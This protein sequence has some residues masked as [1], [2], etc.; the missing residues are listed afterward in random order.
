MSRELHSLPGILTLV[1]DLV[2]LAVGAFGIVHEELT[3]TANPYLLSVYV[4]IVG[5]PAAAHLSRLLPTRAE[6]ESETRTA[7]LS[8]QSQQSHSSQDSDS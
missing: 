1:R 4:L 2:L 6:E 7:G 3:A 8:A 5:A